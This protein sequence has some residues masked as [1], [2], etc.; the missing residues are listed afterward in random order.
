MKGETI[1]FRVHE[2]EVS[3]LG[4]KLYVELKDSGGQSYLRQ[5][6]RRGNGK[7][8]E[9]SLFI[10][11]GVAAGQ[12][13]LCFTNSTRVLCKQKIQLFELNP[14]SLRA[15]L[16]MAQTHHYSGQTMT[17]YFQVCDQNGQAVEGAPVTYY[18]RFAEKEIA[19]TAPNTD[20]DGYSVVTFKVPSHARRSGFLAVGATINKERTL[21]HQSFQ[22]VDK[23]MEIR[24]FPQGSTTEP[25]KLSAMAIQTRNS[26]GYP[27]QAKGEI[28]GSDGQSIGTWTTDAEGIGYLSAVIPVEHSLQV[29]E[30]L[31]IEKTFV[32]PQ[33][34]SDFG[35]ATTV[36]DDVIKVS[37]RN[38][39]SKS[40]DLALMVKG[41]K[42][43]RCPVDFQG[44][45]FATVEWE[46][47]KGL[48]YAELVLLCEGSVVAIEPVMIGTRIKPKIEM[49][50]RASNHFIG[51]AVEYTA[52][53]FFVK[54][55]CRS[56]DLDLVL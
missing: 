36:T 31:G 32:V 6:V 5:R 52:N 21:T 42:R 44:K 18:A 13:D 9:G 2:S 26:F 22:L 12:Y 41:Q 27:V 1:W 37:V 47:K 53:E 49:K 39:S 14:S 25:G 35:L 46:N 3:V 16:Q 17:A 51:E 29:T 38:Q 34:D 33:A 10:K 54:A 15:T 43:E 19:G 30:P 48:E 40:V 55:T 24:F 56:P 28:L 7:I 4:K 20:S 8:L 23:A 50:L 11:D 45:S